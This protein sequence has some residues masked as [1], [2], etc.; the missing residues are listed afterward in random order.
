[1]GANKIIS[2]VF[3]IR[4]IFNVLNAILD[5]CKIYILEDRWKVLSTD[6][7]NVS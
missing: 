4:E 6:P 7:A 3:D 5:E 1:M 2:N